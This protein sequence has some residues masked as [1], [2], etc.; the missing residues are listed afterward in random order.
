MRGERISVVVPA[1]NEEGRIGELVR[2]LLRAE[3]VEVVVADGGSRDK[4]A[5]VARDAGAK[6][7]RA[8]RGR[9]RQM[10]RGAAAAEAD[11]LLFLH[12]D[13]TLPVEYA[14]AVR[15]ALREPGVVAGAFRFRLD[16]RG[17]FLSFITATANFR[18]G[19]LGIIFGD[20]GIFVR[21]ECFF[22]AGG[23]PDQPI[24]EDYEMVRRLKG[25]GRITILPLPATTSARR[26]QEAGPVRNTVMNVV[27]TWAYLLGVKPDRLQQWRR[28]AKKRGGEPGDGLR[29]D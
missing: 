12:A 3:G 25:H 13:T 15:E 19:R 10:N 21:K 11:I 7:V 23:Y 6:I 2:T 8:D 28:R 18:S 14:A 20:Q 26:W 24:M 22:A 27:I 5:A 29:P 16:R 9:G 17:R 1:L 4:T